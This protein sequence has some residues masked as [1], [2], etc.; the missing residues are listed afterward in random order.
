M[1]LA[2]FS[3]SEDDSMV[4]GVSKGHFPPPLWMRTAMSGGENT[5]LP[6]RFKFR[7]S[8]AESL[9]ADR[10]NPMPAI[11]DDPLRR[12][13]AEPSKATAETLHARAGRRRARTSS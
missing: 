5:D 4:A 8:G 10:I 2:P 13:H 3:P 6:D 12:S 7:P 11:N 9:A 1:E